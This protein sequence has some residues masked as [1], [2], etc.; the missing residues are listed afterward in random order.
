MPVTYKSGLGGGAALYSPWLTSPTNPLYLGAVKLYSDTNCI[1][2]V[3]QKVNPNTVNETS[4]IRLAYPITPPYTYQYLTKIWSGYTINAGTSVVNLQDIWILLNP[5]IV[6]GTYYRQEHYTTG[7]A[8]DGQMF[9]QYSMPLFRD[10][11]S[12]DS[13]Q[14]SS[15]SSIIITSNIADLAVN[16]ASTLHDNASLDW[17]SITGEIFSGFTPISTKTTWAYGYVGGGDGNLTIPWETDDEIAYNIAVNLVGSTSGSEIPCG[18]CLRNEPFDNDI[19]RKWEQMLLNIDATAISLYEEDEEKLY[20]SI[21]SGSTWNV[22]ENVY[23]YYQAIS[24]SSDGLKILV[25]SYDV[26]VYYSVDGGETYSELTTPAVGLDYFASDI[27]K[28][29]GTMVLC[30]EYNQYKSTDDGDSWTEIYAFATGYTLPRLKMDSDGTHMIAVNWGEEVS[31]SD[32]SGASWTELTAFFDT[33]Y[34]C[35]IS[36]SGG[37][38]AVLD[39]DG[40]NISIDGGLSWTNHTIGISATR[41]AMDDS[42]KTI[43]CDD[44]SNNI[45]YISADY[46]VTWEQILGPQGDTEVF[47]GDSGLTELFGTLNGNGNYYGVC[48]KIGHAYLCSISSEGRIKSIAGIL[49]EN[50][51]KVGGTPI[52]SLKK[53]SGEEN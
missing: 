43:L 46:G 20:T 53:I 11:E 35:D 2:F 1:L 34:D 23:N 26:G 17:A 41:M 29:G 38:I 14:G 52:A 44:I 3:S 7:L 30:T 19:G 8:G 22:L 12:V 33:P 9:L 5:T 31:Y 40:M 16:L 45:E 25:P 48:Y 24:M 10:V 4:W 28:D 39:A 32:D 15:A 49:F 36:A 21:N 6:N 42:G 27:S 18:T 47:D 37:R 13:Y 51:S 50:I